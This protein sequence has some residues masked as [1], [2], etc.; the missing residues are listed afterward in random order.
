MAIKV[1]KIGLVSALLLILVGGTAYI[2][3]RPGE[4]RAGYVE[5]GR[6]G[7]QGNSRGTRD[8]LD[9]T[10]RDDCGAGESRGYSSPGR[11][12]GN[13]VMLRDPQCE[14]GSDGIAQ[15]RGR[16][17]ASR[18]QGLGNQGEGSLVW[19]QAEAPAWETIQGLVI[20]AGNELLVKTDDGELLVGLGQAFYREEQGFEVAIGDEVE[21][22]GYFEDDEFKAGTVENLT[23]GESIVLRD[24]SGRPMWSGRGNNQNRP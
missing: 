15:G 12:Q 11:G 18:G 10:V 17:L 9:V 14:T 5:Q 4:A 22:R 21:V 13:G 8:G 7:G 1:L 16:E 6:P 23:T 24:D 19:S 3:M 20:E 2:L